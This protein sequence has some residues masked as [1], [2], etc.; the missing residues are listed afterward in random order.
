MRLRIS[1]KLIRTVTG[2]AF[3]DIGHSLKDQRSNRRSHLPGYAAYEISSGDG[4]RWR[5]V[6]FFRAA[7][8][9]NRLSDTI[10]CS[11]PLQRTSARNPRL[12]QSKHYPTPEW[13]AGCSRSHRAV[14]R[15]YD[16]AANVIETHD[17]A[18]ISKSDS[19]GRQ[20]RRPE[21]G[22]SLSGANITMSYQAGQLRC[23]TENQLSPSYWH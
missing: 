15:V 17:H 2:K 10:E 8:F 21:R 19:E 14:I 23:F 13:Y 3:F 11:Q 7:H 16:E 20:L 5:G 9:N 12:C 18:A 22:L 6:H 4:L 1:R